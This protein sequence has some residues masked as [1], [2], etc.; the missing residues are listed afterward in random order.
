MWGARARYASRTALDAA[1]AYER[2]CP[3][4]AIGAPVPELAFAA[5]A[6]SESEGWVIDRLHLYA[7]LFELVID[8]NGSDC[9]D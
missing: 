4:R 9:D 7:A 5:E 2:L 8:E 3:L 1:T 6:I